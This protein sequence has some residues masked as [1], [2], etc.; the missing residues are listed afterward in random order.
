MTQS[1]EAPSRDKNECVIYQNGDSSTKKHW[2]IG[3]V[4]HKKNTKGAFESFKQYIFSCYATPP[5][6]RKNTQIYLVENENDLNSDTKQIKKDEDFERV[7]DIPLNKRDANGSARRYF[8]IKV[9]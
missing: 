7:F 3:K 6:E 5:Q 1:G 4:A 8:N 9:E 2:S